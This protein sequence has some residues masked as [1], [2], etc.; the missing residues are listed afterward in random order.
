MKM[1]IHIPSYKEKL[2]ELSDLDAEETR[3]LLLNVK[4]AIEKAKGMNISIATSASSPSVDA[5]LGELR[6][7]GWNA[8]LVDDFRE[9][10]YILIK[11]GK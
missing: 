5:V 8:N 6:R 2:K 10:R 4:T 11:G 3:A 1:P 9:G 7:L